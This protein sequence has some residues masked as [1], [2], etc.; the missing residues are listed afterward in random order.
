MDFNALIA[1]IVTLILVG[2]IFGILWWGV[3]A[4]GLEEPFNRVVRG[5]IILAVVI[6]LI[7][8][9]TGNAPALRWRN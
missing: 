3:G 5:L 8:V 6:Y 4:I 1:I 7:G 9:L 2:L